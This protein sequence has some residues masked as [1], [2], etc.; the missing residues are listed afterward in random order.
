MLVTI[1]PDAMHTF[2]L[3]IEGE[4]YYYKVHRIR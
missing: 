2:T 3:S 4:N 1:K